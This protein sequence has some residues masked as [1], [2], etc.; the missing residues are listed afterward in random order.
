MS[1]IRRFVF[2]DQGGETLE[3][4]LVLGF[5]V[6]SAATA[7]ASA[8]ANVTAWWGNISTSLTTLFG[9]S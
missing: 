3:Y 1:L 7:V 2:D 8:S 6:L 4:G 9:S 5:C